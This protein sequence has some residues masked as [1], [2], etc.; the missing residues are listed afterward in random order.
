MKII[1]QGRKVSLVKMLLVHGKKK[2]KN[3]LVKARLIKMLF[4]S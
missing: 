3:V 1:S 2:N 4:E